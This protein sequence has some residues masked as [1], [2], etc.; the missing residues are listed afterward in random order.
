MLQFRKNARRNIQPP[1]GCDTLGCSF[2]EPVKDQ[3]FAVTR[4]FLCANPKCG[5]VC[6]VERGT[7]GRGLLT[8]LSVPVDFQQY[9]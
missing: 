7:I 6:K 8:D 2:V 3:P 1:S 4:E 5:A 9:S